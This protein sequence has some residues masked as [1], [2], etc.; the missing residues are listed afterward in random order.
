MHW[1]LNPGK[2]TMLD[3]HHTLNDS[4]DLFF[5]FSSVA[6]SSQPGVLCKSFIHLT[7]S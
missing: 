2:D 5:L 3:C 4:F 6:H 1:S 7:K